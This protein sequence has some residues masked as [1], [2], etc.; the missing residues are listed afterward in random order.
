M[1][2][3]LTIT[4]IILLLFTITVSFAWMM[5]IMGPSAEEVLI[6]FDNSVYL[7]PNNLKIDISIEE[8]G[9]YIPTYSSENVENVLACFDNQAPGDVLKFS[10]KINNLTNTPISTAISFSEMV[11]SND[12]FYNHIAVG[13][14]YTNGFDNKYKAPEFNEFKLSERM[15]KDAEGNLIINDINSVNF[16]KE[17]VIPPSGQ[18]IEF[19]FYIKFDHTRESQNHLQNQTFTIGKI[20]F[21]CI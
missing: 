8:N 20:N 7:S 9:E 12:D 2:K 17:L 18:E 5:D 10:V 13:L 4:T 11:A 6:N 15:N 16:I 21:M 14:F 1:Y 19:R 3:K